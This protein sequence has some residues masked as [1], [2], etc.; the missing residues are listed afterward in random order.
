ME[1]FFRGLDAETLG[2][3]A[4]IITGLTLLIREVRNGNK[5]A[6]AA[7]VVKIEQAN[8]N[9]EAAGTVPVTLASP[10]VGLTGTGDGGTVKAGTDLLS[11]VTTDPPP[12]PPPFAPIPSPVTPVT[13][14]ELNATMLRVAEALERFAPAPPVDGGR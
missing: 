11:K 7:N 10:P 12:T 6:E 4:A 1:E 8:R 13:N 2:Q 14:A 5:Q 9:L 3:W